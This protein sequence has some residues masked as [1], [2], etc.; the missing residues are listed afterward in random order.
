MTG[1]AVDLGWRVAFFPQV[2]TAS[3]W[4][5]PVGGDAKGWFDLILLRDRFL[6]V[7]LKGDG[8][9]MRVEQKEW[10]AA[11]RLIATPES[12]IEARVWVP[13]DWRSG[14]IRRALERRGPEQADAPDDLQLSLTSV[15]LP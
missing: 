2:K 1:E 11:A 6:L 15:V 4:R 7:E 13:E 12:K 14:T 5:V 3:G 10:L 9:R 8:D